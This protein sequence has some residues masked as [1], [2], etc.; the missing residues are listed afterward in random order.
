M[1]PIIGLDL[2]NFDKIYI[3]SSGDDSFTP[4]I[5]E[6]KDFTF[7]VVGNEG[8][9]TLLINESDGG[10]V[11]GGDGNDKIDAI[12]IHGQLRIYGGDG[13]DDINF[14]SSEYS[15][16]PVYGGNGSDTIS[17]GNVDDVL[18]G[19]SGDDILFGKERNDNLAGDNGNDKLYGGR[20]KDAL[21]GGDGN[22]K[23]KGGKGRDFLRGDAGIDT[24]IGGRGRDTFELSSGKDIVKDFDLDSGEKIVIDGLNFGDNPRISQ[25]GNDVRIRGMGGLDAFLENVNLPEFLAADAIEFTYYY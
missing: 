14:V 1:A 3:G 22:D 2:E 24:M 7:Y 16:S 17:G 21:Y 10:L 13:N 11:L 19:D 5:S 25:Q 4:T 12:Y 8:N 18:H 6:A 20:A 15:F 23:L 9:D